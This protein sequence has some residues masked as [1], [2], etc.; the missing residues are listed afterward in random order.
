MSLQLDGAIRPEQAKRLSEHLK[1]CPR[2][3]AAWAAM[4]RAHGLLGQRSWTEPTPELAARVLARLPRGRRAVIPPAPAWSRATVVVVVALVFVLVG[5]TGALLL[6]GAALGDGAWA[7]L[8][9]GGRSVLVAGWDSLG[10]LWAA[11]TGVVGAL[12]EALRWPWLPI[13]V[14]VAVV[15]G[16]AW[17]W[18]WIRG[19]G[20]S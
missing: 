13:A 20:R 6:T 8:E 4:H 3:Q 10:H 11:L 7:A 2:C 12:W 5:V 1:Q 16:L 9:Q 15:A 18:L 19:R 14:A 17:G